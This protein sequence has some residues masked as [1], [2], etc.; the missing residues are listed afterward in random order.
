MMV[1]LSSVLT[2]TYLPVFHWIIFDS[3]YASFSD[4]NGVVRTPTRMGASNNEIPVLSHSDDDSIST[5]AHT[6]NTISINTQPKIFRLAFSSTVRMSK[7]VEAGAW[8]PSS[9]R[10]KYAAQVGKHQLNLVILGEPQLGF[11][12]GKLSRLGKPLQVRSTCCGSY[13]PS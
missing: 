12:G 4:V 7:V 10:S 6:V 5:V 9:W 13:A 8:S 1:V 11:T 3:S 2:V